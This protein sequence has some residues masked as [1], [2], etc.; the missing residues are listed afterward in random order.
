MSRITCSHCSSRAQ[1]STSPNSG[2][3]PPGCSETAP[4]SMMPK[5]PS[6]NSMKLPG[7]GSACTKPTFSGDLTVNSSIKAPA[8]SRSSRVPSEMIFESR[9]P[10]IHSAMITLGALATTAGTKNFGS[11]VKAFANA[12]WLD[13]S[14]R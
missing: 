5:R 13:A 1:H 2:G 10:S 3:M 4:K 11:S 9:R 8:E 6:G 14:W 7:C 12:R